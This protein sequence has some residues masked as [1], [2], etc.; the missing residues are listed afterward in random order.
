MPEFAPPPPNHDLLP[1]QQFERASGIRT[2][3]W[4]PVV[5]G[6]YEAAA[7]LVDME[8]LRQQRCAASVMQQLA[9]PFSDPAVTKV[10]HDARQ[11]RSH[12]PRCL[13]CCTSLRLAVYWGVADPLRRAWCAPRRSSCIANPRAPQSS[14][15]PT[16][17][18]DLETAHPRYFACRST[19]PACHPM[20]SA[21]EVPASTATRL[22]DHKYPCRSDG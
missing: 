10:L 14:R 21:Y 16:S 11:V 2:T 15:W 8:A 18:A 1:Q 9:A 7:Y 3:N 4:P 17:C 12:G 22:N 13:L 5:A 20:C 6:S 19:L